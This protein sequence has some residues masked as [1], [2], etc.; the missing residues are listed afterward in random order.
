MFNSIKLKLFTWFL[1]IFSFILTG[2]G[3]FLY[4]ELKNFVMAQVDHQLNASLQTIADV[5]LIEE[6]H[7]QLQ[8]ELWELANVQRGE[9]A[10]KLSGHYYQ[11]TSP[12]GEVLSRSPSLW[13]A[14]ITLPIAKGSEVSHFE[15]ITGPKNIPL[16]I[17]SQT[18]NFSLGPLTL[19][20][21]D[22]LDDTSEILEN[23][24]NIIIFTL[25]VVSIIA[26]FGGLL[27][28]S[29]TLRPLKTFSSKIG[30]ITEENLSDRV[31]E[32]GLDNEL[33]PLAVSFN[34]MLGRIEEAFARQR[35]FLSDASHELRTPTSIIKSYCDVTLGKERTA[36]DYRN[37]LS[38]V[39]DSVNRMCDLI[40]RILVISRLDTTT[41]QIRP[42]RVN[43]NLILKDVIKLLDA[44]AANKETTI[45][46]TEKSVIVNCD[47]EAITEVLTNLTENA[48][49]YNKQG[50]SINIDISED[51]NWVI[52]TVEDTGIGI[53]SEE[54][55]KIFDRFYRVDTSRGQ[56]TGSGL[57]LAIVKGII[58]AHGGKIEVESAV[59]KGSTF[60]V[61]LPK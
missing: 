1:V 14:N 9:Y 59:G 43:L 60:R 37:A 5:M 21:G 36:A 27:I 61:Y 25:P 45:N 50:G 15:T 2:L 53:P 13:L 46:F 32:N 24:R 51:N 34:K 31:D 35:Q 44:T 3:V 40:N 19:Q 22:A 41:M 58:E 20:M 57:G 12:T 6:S 10:E 55:P 23:F 26:G 11:I 8:M 52:T 16:R 18:M 28:T 49:K 38:K 42:A 39:G 17:T 56:T 48:I 7:G 4:F 47:R 54:I 29:K 30:Q 33:Q